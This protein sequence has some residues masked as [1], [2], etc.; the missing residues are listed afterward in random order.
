MEREGERMEKELTS[1]TRALMIEIEK[2]KHINE[3]MASLLSAL[4]QYK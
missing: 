1:K 2:T 4:G 3:E